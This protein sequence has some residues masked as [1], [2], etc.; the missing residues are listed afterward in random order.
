MKI[1]AKK[2]AKSKVKISLYKKGYTLKSFAQDV[3]KKT[4][5]HIGNVIRGKSNPSPEIAKQ[6]AEELHLKWEDV[7]E[8]VE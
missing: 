2:H 5:Q 4:E 7:W 6:I 1:I 8:M 3:M